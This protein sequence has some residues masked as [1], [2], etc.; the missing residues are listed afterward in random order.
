MSG[1][2]LPEQE[3]DHV[4]GAWLFALAA[5]ALAVALL[6]VTSAWLLLRAGGSR[7]PPPAPLPKAAFGPGT[8]EQAPIL[9]PPRGLALQ[10]LQ[11]RR[12][13]EYG[14]VDRDAGIA[15]IPIERAIELRAEE[16]R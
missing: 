10:A 1:A 7:T 2:P 6:A 5:L 16:S 14:W 13:G 4:R 3:P 8:P 12:L 15:H 9:G 11:R